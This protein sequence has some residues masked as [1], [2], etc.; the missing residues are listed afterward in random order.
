MAAKGILRTLTGNRVAFW[1]PGCEDW[2]QVTIPPGAYAWG[3]NE[4]YDAPTFTPS[5]LVQGKKGLTDDEYKRVMRGETVETQPYRCHSFVTDG[6]IQFLGD[7]THGLSG[8]TV[9]LERRLH[10]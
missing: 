9:R 8:Q 6:S 3:F 10:G 7:C 5:V 4:N 2:H 1:C